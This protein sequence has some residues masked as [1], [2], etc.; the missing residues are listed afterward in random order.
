M[1]LNNGV[2]LVTQATRKLCAPGLQTYRTEIM[3]ECALQR[4]PSLWDAV[5]RVIEVHI[6]G[7]KPHN[8]WEVA[9]RCKWTPVCCSSVSA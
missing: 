4:V 5:A 2:Q 6:I 7:L 3:F 1:T 9:Y 8:V